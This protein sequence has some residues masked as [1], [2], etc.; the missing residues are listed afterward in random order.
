MKNTLFICL[1]LLLSGMSNAQSPKDFDTYK[2]KHPEEMAVYLQ[3]NQS[4][5]I[6]LEGDSISLDVEEYSDLLHLDERSK[7]LSKDK[8][9]LTGFR[10]LTRLEAK[11][12]IPNRNKYKEI[13]IDDF[14]EKDEVS[15]GIFYDDFKSISFVYPSISP[16]VRTVLN[17]A[18]SITNP[19][20]VS[21]FYFGS[22]LPV[23]STK[24]EVKVHKNINL[25]YKTFHTEEIDLQ[26]KK[27]TKGDYIIYSWACKNLD[28]YESEPGTPS[29]SYFLPH[30]AYYIGSYTNKAGEK[31][32]VGEKIDDLYGWYS[33][34]TCNVNKDDDK[35]LKE[36]VHSLIKDIDSEEEKVKKIFYW[37]QDNIKYVA[38]E[39]GMRGFIPHN[40]GYIYEKRYGDCK[41][42]ASITN[43]MLRMAGITSYLTWIGSRD[44]PYRYSELPTPMVDNHMIVAYQRPNGEF[45]FLDATSSNT[46]YGL[47]SAFIQ[48]KEALLSI[49]PDEYKVV[50]VPVVDRK[51][52]VVADTTYIKLDGNSILGEGKTDLTGYFRVHNLYRL[53]GKKDEEQE[54]FMTS[55]LEKGNNKFFIEDYEIL[56]KEDKDAPLSIE[57]SYK[58]E[59]YIST[60]GDEIYI[61]MSLDKPYFNSKIKD[62]RK[63]PKESDYQY[64]SQTVSV[65][66]IPEGYDISYLPKNSDYAH[67]MF[68]FSITYKREGNKLYQVREIYLDYLLLPADNFSSWNEMIV[69]LGKAYREAI[70][71]KKK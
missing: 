15:A 57:Y 39:Q 4:V 14:V 58:I 61:N 8:V 70:I 27:E 48:G 71:L 16:G 45:Y 6:D 25:K 38:F 53:D 28:S 69:T 44:I 66:E 56:N 1:L 64:T 23:T 19:R 12:L 46:Y 43:N 37:V 5:T 33:G 65:F 51:K 50:E 67:D 62:G 49:T 68:G 9:Y 2:A 59:D 10:K 40:A 11:T 22:F 60:V 52:N 63:L 26:F 54:L 24:L 7:A 18:E 31:I 42:M 29:G 21:P 47:P 34:L 17:Q 36:I 20:F 3:L 55:F 30:I 35:E 32:E 41:D 13:I